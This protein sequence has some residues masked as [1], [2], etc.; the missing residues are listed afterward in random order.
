M[1]TGIPE[2]NEQQYNSFIRAAPAC[3]VLLTGP[4][5]LLEIDRI[6]QTVAWADKKLRREL[7]A[8]NRTWGPGSETLRFWSVSWA[9][10]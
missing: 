2:R 6:S 1:I 8:G 10:G 4:K 7:E 5:P 9:W 3:K